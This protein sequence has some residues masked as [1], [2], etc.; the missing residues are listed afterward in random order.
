[1]NVHFFFFAGIHEC[2]PV[3]TESYAEPSTSGV[4]CTREETESRDQKVSITDMRPQCVYVHACVCMCVGVCVSAHNPKGS[5]CSVLLCQHCRY[6]F[7]LDSLLVSLLRDVQSIF[8]FNQTGNMTLA[9]FMRFS[10]M[11][12]CDPHRL[13]VVEA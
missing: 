11:C 9:L 6:Y 8:F 7:G 10:L 5:Q 13:I 1:M 12:V 3:D 4:Y 2:P